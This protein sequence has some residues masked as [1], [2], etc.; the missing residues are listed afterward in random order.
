MQTPGLPGNASVGVR[1]ERR[2]LLVPEV[3]AAGCRGLQR[4][5]DVEVGAAHEV[6]QGIHPFLLERPRY[7]IASDDLAHACL[8]CLLLLRIALAP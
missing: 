1:R 2:S 3:H 4:H 6:E 5:Y 7:E 8:S